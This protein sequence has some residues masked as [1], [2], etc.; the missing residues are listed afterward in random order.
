[1]SRDKLRLH[2][3]SF[4]DNNELELSRLVIDNGISYKGHIPV[5]R[6]HLEAGSPAPM[7]SIRR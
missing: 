7:V 3:G 5:V 6:K 2:V 1:M 4:G